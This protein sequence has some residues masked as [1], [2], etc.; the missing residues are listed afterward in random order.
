MIPILPNSNKFIID[1]LHLHKLEASNK[2]GKVISFINSEKN[3]PMIRTAS[4]NGNNGNDKII[5]LFIQILSQLDIKANGDNLPGI[6]SNLTNNDSLNKSSST[7]KNSQSKHDDIKI[8]SKTIRDSHYQ[9]DISK[10]AV[11]KEGNKVHM[12]SCYARDAYLG[13]YLIKR[14]YFFSMDREKSADQAY[15]EILTK[16]GSLKD[17]Y[18]NEVIDVSELSKQMKQILD[19]VVSELKLEQD[20]L[21]TNINRNPLA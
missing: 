2:I 20:S 13:R 16:M 1:D 10:D 8:V 21:A 5:S 3:E 4:N 18:Y 9:I 19:G 11:S 12:I 7:V 6:I 15:D 17:R 14:N